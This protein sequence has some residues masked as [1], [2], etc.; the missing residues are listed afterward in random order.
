MQN[1]QVIFSFCISSELPQN[2][3][4]FCNNK[5]TFTTLLRDY[6]V[7]N[8][9]YPIEEF[10]SAVHNDVDTWT[11]LLDLHYYCVVLHKVALSCCVF[12]IFSLWFV[13][14]LLVL[15]NFCNLLIWLGCILQFGS[16]WDEFYIHSDL[17]RLW[18]CEWICICVYVCMYISRWC[19]RCSHSRK[20]IWEA[21]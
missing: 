3:L 9:F 1:L 21:G 5:H 13:M 6:L 16:F 12:V 10:L 8:G 15:C 18:I 4:K 7:K 19:T 2:I 20:C 14:F 11:F 17:R